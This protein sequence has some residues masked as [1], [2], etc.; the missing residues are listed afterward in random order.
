MKYYLNLDG[1]RHPLTVER[2]EFMRGSSWT[3]TYCVQIPEGAID[4][5]TAECIHYALIDGWTTSGTL[6]DDDIHWC[7]EDEGENLVH[8]DD[9][10]DDL[11]PGRLILKQRFGARD[12]LV[13][14]RQ[15]SAGRVDDYVHAYCRTNN[16]RLVYM[17]NFGDLTVAVTEDKCS[18]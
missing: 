13:E 2:V 7:I 5:F 15:I 12:V 11:N 16:M 3:W 14:A 1:T 9:L 6:G 4:A 8:R 18:T 10:E 17:D